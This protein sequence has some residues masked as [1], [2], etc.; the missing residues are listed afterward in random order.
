MSRPYP[1]LVTKAK[2]KQRGNGL[3]QA[4]AKKRSKHIGVMKSKHS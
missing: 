2:L 1:R 3:E 4:Q